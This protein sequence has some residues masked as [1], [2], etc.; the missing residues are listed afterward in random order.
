MTKLTSDVL[1]GAIAPS[2]LVADLKQAGLS[3]EEEKKLLNLY[4]VDQKNDIFISDRGAIYSAMLSLDAGAVER[5]FIG[6]K[7]ECWTHGGSVR[8]DMI[9]T[10]KYDLKL[11]PG[12]FPFVVRRDGEKP[13]IVWSSHLAVI[14]NYKE[15]L[16]AKDAAIQSAM[17]NACAGFRIG[18]KS[19]N[20]PGALSSETVVWQRPSAG[21]DYEDYILSTLV[22]DSSF[23]VADGYDFFVN[24]NG[25]VLNVFDFSELSDSDREVAEANVVQKYS[26]MYP[27]YELSLQ[28]NRSFPMAG[29]DSNSSHILYISNY[30]EHLVS[31][32]EKTGST[33]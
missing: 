15:L 25:A 33:K 23:Q 4:R 19:S 10:R 1:W 27:Q 20:L 18:D 26:D 32:I 30:Q 16:D 3:E 11:V 12:E 21:L 7:H 31:S 14:A 28:K 5:W 29:H 17:D 24:D 8:Y 6:R 13:R 2:S 9:D 22:P